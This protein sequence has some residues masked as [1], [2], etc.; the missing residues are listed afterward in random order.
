MPVDFLAP[1]FLSEIGGIDISNCLDSGKVKSSCLP[2]PQ[3]K[4]QRNIAVGVPYSAEAK[5][6]DLP[7]CLDCA[8]SF[9]G[10]LYISQNFSLPTRTTKLPVVL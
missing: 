9:E 2:T 5:H 1:K 8:G 10:R 7:D 4:N 3:T 6:L